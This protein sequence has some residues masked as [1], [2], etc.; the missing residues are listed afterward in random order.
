MKYFIMP[1]EGPMIKT[2]GLSDSDAKY[3]NIIDALVANIDEKEANSLKEKGFIIE[4]DNEYFIPLPIVSP[5]LQNSN[6]YPNIELDPSSLGYMKQMETT[7]VEKLRELGYFGKS[8][9]YVGIAD[10]GVDAS[11]PD[12]KDN[13]KA[14]K[15]F[16]DISNTKP[17]DP[18]G[19]GSAVAGCICGKGNCVE[20]FHGVAPDVSFAMARVMDKD[21]SGSE[22][23]ILLGIDW[24]VDQNV[25]IINLSLGSWITRYTPFSKAVDNVVEKGIVVCVAAGN[26]GPKQIA[27]PANAVNAITCSACNKDGEYADFSSLGPAKGPDSLSLDKPDVMAWGHYIALVHAKNSSMG[28]KIDDNYVY[29]S[30]TS[31]AT[32]FTTGAVA[33]LKSEKPDLLPSEIKTLLM[34]T[35][36]DSEKYDKYH[37]GAGNLRVFDALNKLLDGK[38]TPETP[39]DT[40]S[41]KGCLGAMLM[42]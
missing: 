21:G 23:N 8:D 1:K 41:K 36:Y 29:A 16:V 32:P 10:S 2:L 34:E 7:G 22:S 12:I 30:G 26:D 19:H 4:P 27:A 20:K 17:I 5:H 6:Y 40:P 25:S 38:L 35:S 31:F 24:L 9:V 11:H 15:D 39:S 37:E 14:F 28:T 3:I 42:V 33:L 13:L 18:C